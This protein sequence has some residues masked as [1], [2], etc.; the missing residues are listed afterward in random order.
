MCACAHHFP[1]GN[2]PLLPAPPDPLGR[3]AVLAP[4]TRNHRRWRFGMPA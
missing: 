3:L 1:G 2:D 4:P